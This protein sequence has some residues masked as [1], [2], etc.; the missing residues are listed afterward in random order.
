MTFSDPM[1]EFLEKEKNARGL[2]S[3][4]ET[5]RQIVSQTIVQKDTVESG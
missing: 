3:V 1:Y 4:Q 5:L 2:E